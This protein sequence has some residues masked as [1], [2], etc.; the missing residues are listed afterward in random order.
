MV[1][2]TIDLLL[3]IAGI[4][5][6]SWLVAEVVIRVTARAL[7][8]VGASPYLTRSIRDGLTIVWIIFAVSGTLLVTGVASEFSFL[9]VSGIVG[10]TVSLALQSTLSNVIAGLLLLTDRVIRIGDVISFSSVKGTVVRIGLR[11]TWL[12]TES[13]EIVVT[14]NSNLAS[15]PFVNYSAAQRLERRLRA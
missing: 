9:T 11:S 14:S 1:Q 7:R 3:Q 8:S 4:V 10:L 6:G 15:G 5:V 13:G 2:V 12:K